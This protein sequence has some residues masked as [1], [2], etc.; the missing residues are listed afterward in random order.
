MPRINARSKGASGE[1][2][3]CNWLFTRGLVRRMPERNLEQV[4]SGGIDVIPED[5]P[6]AYEVKRVEKYPAPYD[7]WWYKANLDAKKHNREAVVAHRRNNEDW[8]FLISL[9]NLLG[10]KGS[11]AIVGS[12]AFIKYAQKRI[13]GYKHAP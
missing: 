13:S 9:E 11:Y 1:R 8:S 10:V 5:H 7:K 3:F 2:E 4:R 6:F 12:V